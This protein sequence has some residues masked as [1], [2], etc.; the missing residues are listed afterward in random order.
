MVKILYLIILNFCVLCFVHG[1][2]ANELFSGAVRGNA[3]IKVEYNASLNIELSSKGI[4]RISFWPLRVEKLICDLSNFTSNVPDNGTD[5]FLTSKVPAG[6]T[7]N[8]SVVLSTGEPIDLHIKVVESREPKY[9]SLDFSN[10]NDDPNGI[11]KH[12]S[13]LMINAMKN[14]FVG[15]YYVRSIKSPTLLF[16]TKEYRVKQRSN[17]QYDRLIGAVLEIENKR[18]KSIEIDTKIIISRFEGSQAFAFESEHLS[19][20]SKT[21]GYVVFKSEEGA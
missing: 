9:I 8:A 13:A 21:K 5:I 18:N 3:P 11:L 19:P 17:Y 2:M 14:D 20:K 6:T 16:E 7:L 15:K 12:E 10:L 4:N 1:A